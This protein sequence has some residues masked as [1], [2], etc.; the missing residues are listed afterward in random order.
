MLAIERCEKRRNYLLNQIREYELKRVQKIRIRKRESILNTKR[1][2]KRGKKRASKQRYGRPSTP[3][4]LTRFKQASPNFDPRRR[5]QTALGS[6]SSFSTTNKQSRPQMNRPQSSPT[7]RSTS[8]IMNQMATSSKLLST[9]HSMPALHAVTSPQRPFYPAQD[10]AFHK[11]V[12]KGKRRKKKRPASAAVVT[13]KNNK[14]CNEIGPSPNI[15][16]FTNEQ[17]R[18]PISAIR[19]RSGVSNTGTRS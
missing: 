6:S 9:T 7:R 10:H 4:T 11:V 14:F 16:H 12:Q 3:S 13:G 18:R 2:E 8:S 5:P 1:A 19:P 17:N 15:N